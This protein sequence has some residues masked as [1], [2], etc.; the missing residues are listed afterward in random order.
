MTTGEGFWLL[1]LL[2]AAAGALPHAYPIYLVAAVTTVAALALSA[3]FRTD[4]TPATTM[5]WL[6]WLLIAFLCLLSPDYPWYFL[7]L[8]PFVAL[9]R[10]ATPWAL[11]VGAFVLN[12]AIP[13]DSALPLTTREWLLYGAA[14]IAIIFDL[15]S[16]RPIGLLKRACV[17]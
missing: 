1:S 4:R 16:R 10:L 2:E 7:V 12:D 8:T 15:W 11:T 3:G 14:S 5:T 9:T 6:A 13:D 17:R